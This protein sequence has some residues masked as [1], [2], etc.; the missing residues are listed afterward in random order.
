MAFRVFLLA[1]ALAGA[2][3]VK[4]DLAMT[5]V[6]TTAR[7]GAITVESVGA[8]YGFPS[9]IVKLTPT[10]SN[11]AQT[12]RCSFTVPAGAPSLASIANAD[13]GPLFF[14]VMIASSHAGFDGSGNLGDYL[15]IEVSTGST[16]TVLARLQGRRTNTGSNSPLISVQGPSFT[17]TGKA[18]QWGAQLPGTI[19]PSLDIR[20]TATSEV[21]YLGSAAVHTGCGQQ[22]IE[23]AAS[24][25]S[26]TSLGSVLHAQLLELTPCYM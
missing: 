15:E 18:R 6:D 4:Y 5:C 26:S 9:K 17:V 25:S 3:A 23:S 2:S 11:L 16:T 7:S 12:A 22:A 14:S 24:V 13:G 19:L 1:L 21:I 8:G 20:L 10:R